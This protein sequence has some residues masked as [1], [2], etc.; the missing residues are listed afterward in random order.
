MYIT[1]DLNLKKGCEFD[2]EKYF[3]QLGK[4]SVFNQSDIQKM[5][6]KVRKHL[7]ENTMQ[8][9]FSLTEVIRDIFSDF[10]MKEKPKILELGAGTGFLTRCLI[11]QYEGSGVLVDNN[12]NSF[13][14]YS[15]LNDK[16]SGPIKYIV[17]D[18]FDL[19]LEERYDIICSFGLIEHFK[20]KSEVINIHKKFLKPDGYNLIIVPFDSILT[21]IFF[22]VHLELNLGYRELLSERDLKSILIKQKLEI[23]NVKIS[24]GYAYDFIAALCIPVN[25]KL[26]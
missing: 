11:E 8:L 13:K 14:S 20:D 3:A 10:K 15:S 9:T 16:C 24:R 22:D 7:T 2:W 25:S 26:D 1:Q 21:R 4:S 17:Q 23:L 12:E 18:I 19:N 5:I 6:E